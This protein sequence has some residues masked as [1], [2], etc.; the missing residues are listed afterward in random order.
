MPTDERKGKHRKYRN[1][2]NTVVKAAENKYFTELLCNT[3]QSEKSLWD[4]FGP[5]INPGKKKKSITLKS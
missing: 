2:L 3:K 1:I 5:I 4:T